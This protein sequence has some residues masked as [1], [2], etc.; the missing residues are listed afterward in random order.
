MTYGYV[1]LDYSLSMY[2]TTRFYSSLESD[3]THQ[4]PNTSCQASSLVPTVLKDPSV[5]LTGLR[6]FLG[7]QIG[8]VE[9]FTN[10]YMGL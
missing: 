10:L 2:Y 6:F 5:L 9:D 4:V 3:K 1:L 8:K 7:S